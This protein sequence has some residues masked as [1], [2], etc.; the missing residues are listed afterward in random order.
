LESLQQSDQM[1][2]KKVQTNSMLDKAHD[3]VHGLM[4]VLE[5]HG[6]HF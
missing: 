4:R 6:H 5:H 3:A 2:L 1:H